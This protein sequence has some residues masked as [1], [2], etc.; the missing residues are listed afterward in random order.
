MDPVFQTAY[1]LCKLGFYFYHSEC[2]KNILTSLLVGIYT[3]LE[4]VQKFFHVN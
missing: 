4:V 1:Q 2:Q 3:F